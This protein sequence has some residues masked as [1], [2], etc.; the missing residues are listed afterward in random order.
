MVPSEMER[1][2][3]EARDDKCG[4]EDNYSTGRTPHV[5]TC[6]CLDVCLYGKTRIWQAFDGR[7]RMGRTFDGNT[8]MWQT[9]DGK[10]W[11]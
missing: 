7:N 8:W 2:R 3:M 1:R 5:K 10:T 4:G 6:G 11:I 9:F